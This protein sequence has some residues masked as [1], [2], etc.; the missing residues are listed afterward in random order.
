LKEQNIETTSGGGYVSNERYAKD[1]LVNETGRQS[2]AYLRALTRRESL[3]DLA[4]I[5]GITFGRQGHSAKAAAYLELAARLN[6][7]NAAAWSNLII[8]SK[9]MAKRPNGPDA[10][11]YLELA[12]EGSK[13]LD[14]LGFVHPRDIPQFTAAGRRPT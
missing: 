3:G 8:A 9:M 13:K 1:F 14:E 7:R 6:P 12:A 11:K 5:N 2:G 10:K 4:V